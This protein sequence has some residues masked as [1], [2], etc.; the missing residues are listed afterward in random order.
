MQNLA[1]EFAAGYLLGRRN[2]KGKLTTKTITDNGTYKAKDEP[3][4]QDEKKYDGYSEVTV[5]LAL[6]TKTIVSNDTY[7]ASADSLK[8]YSSVTVNVPTYEQE[9]Q[10]AL[11]RIEE[12]EEQL[13]EM[14][15][16][17]EEK[18]QHLMELTGIKAKDFAELDQLIDLAVDTG[19]VEEEP[20]TP[21]AEDQETTDPENPTPQPDI[22]VI[23][24]RINDN[25]EEP[26]I[27][28]TEQNVGGDPDCIR[29]YFAIKGLGWYSL[30]IDKSNKFWIRESSY[31]ARYAQFFTTDVRII[32]TK[33]DEHGN[34]NIVYSNTVEADS[35]GNYNWAYDEDYTGDPGTPP[36]T[37][38]GW[39][40]SSDSPNIWV[41]KTYINNRP[42]LVIVTR[43]WS[44]SG[45][46]VNQYFHTLNIELT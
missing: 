24:E 31:Y 30:R 3:V 18:Q 44:M 1:D 32:V 41:Y 34:E 7:P 16:G 15:D 36:G 19:K 45:P 12:L 6:G 20:E 14:T 17:F 23:V 26:T 4:G 27:T 25:N 38:K 11:D 43:C 46:Q 37:T 29:S 35:Y 8:G 9:Y 28:E 5:N 40:G 13:D 42:T 2:G 22:D 21:S 10:D 33:F 39:K